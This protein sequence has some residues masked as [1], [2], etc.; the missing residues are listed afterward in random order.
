MHYEALELVDTKV[1]GST[2]KRFYRGTRQ[3]LFAG[4]N[5]EL[6]PKSVQDGVAGAAL[7][8]FSRVEP[9]HLKAGRSAPATTAI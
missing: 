4:A 2:V 5:W 1:V 9:A 8:D 6:L 3:A 7:Q